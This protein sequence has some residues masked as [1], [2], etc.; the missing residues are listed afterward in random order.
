MA[1]RTHQGSWTVIFPYTN[2][3]GEYKYNGIVHW[4]PNWIYIPFLLKWMY[5][6]CCCL[7]VCIYSYDLVD[8]IS[9]DV[10]RVPCT[11][12]R[13]KWFTMGLRWRIFKVPGPILSI[14]MI[15]GTPQHLKSPQIVAEN[16]RE[17]KLSVCMHMCVYVHVCVCV[18]VCSSACATEVGHSVSSWKAGNTCT[19]NVNGKVLN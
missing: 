17:P 19:D 14:L 6:C 4:I 2:Q 7:C 13:N 5:L 10:L 1:L 8:L 18:Y 12:F 15:W 9:H 11:F 16:W 3:S